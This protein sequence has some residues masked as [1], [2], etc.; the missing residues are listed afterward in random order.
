MKRLRS[1]H[2]IIWLL[3]F[4]SILF[5]GLQQLIFHDIHETGFL[6]FQDLLFLPLHILLVTFILDRILRLRERRERLEQ[7]NIVISAFFSEAGTETL[8]V[9]SAMICDLDVISKRLDMNP[10]W[11]KEDFEAAAKAIKSSEFNI[12]IKADS[13]KL[14]KEVLP[15]KKDYLLQMFS[16]PNL[17][18]HNTFTDMLWALYHL[19]DELENRPDSLALPET[20]M[21]HLSGD[22][23][24]AYGL[25]VYEWIFYMRHLKE[26]YP[27]LWSLA[28]RKNPF[29]HNSIVV[30]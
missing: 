23:T 7:I 21:K 14:L 10:G 6:I 27:Y 3:I 12:D 20:D 1:N 17:L 29:A 4:F 2:V 24:R 25:L 8:K 16:N 5:F 19:I 26:K 11:R 28:V 22:I 30:N 18:E 9:L 15:N 13:I